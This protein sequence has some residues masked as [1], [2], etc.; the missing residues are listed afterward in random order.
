MKF[1]KVLFMMVLFFGLTI[2]FFMDQVYA[3]N[4]PKKMMH[5]LYFLTN[6]R[7]NYTLSAENGRRF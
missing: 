2:V 3:S 7:G 1:K 5:I 6:I 4:G